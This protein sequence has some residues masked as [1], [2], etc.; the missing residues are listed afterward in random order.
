MKK[1]ALLLS[2]IRPNGGPDR[3]DSATT[4][5]YNSNYDYLLK[6]S[7]GYRRS[8]AI[9]KTANPTRKGGVRQQAEA[10]P[11]GLLLFCL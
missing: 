8:I 9:A 7:A 10:A 11:R 4:H 6:P 1:I 2:R 3:P 5:S